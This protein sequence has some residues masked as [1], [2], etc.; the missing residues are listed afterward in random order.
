MEISTVRNKFRNLRK[1]DAHLEM[2]RHLIAQ[3][4]IANSDVVAMIDKELEKAR[5]SLAQV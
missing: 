2:A 5:E 1:A 4:P 3:Y